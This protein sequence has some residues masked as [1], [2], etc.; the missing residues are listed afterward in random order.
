MITLAV[1]VVS[2]ESST[3]I[4]ARTEATD[5]ATAAFDPEFKLRMQQCGF[6][7]TCCHRACDAAKIA[8]SQTT[9]PFGFSCDY[10]ANTCKAQCGRKVRGNLTPGT[11][12]WVCAAKH[13][14]RDT[15]TTSTVTP[16]TCKSDGGRAATVLEIVRP[17]A[18]ELFDRST[19]HKIEYEDTQE[20]E[21]L[22]FGFKYDL[23][24]A[25]RE[26]EKVK[27]GRLWFCRGE[28]SPSVSRN[29]DINGASF[30]STSGSVGGNSNSGS[31]SSSNSDSAFV[32]TNLRNLRGS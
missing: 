13:A 16:S 18:W 7:G 19:R 4:C 14:I 11:K 9:G 28:T 29:N 17:P 21:T 10:L 24:R 6:L 31:G 26:G 12:I 22:K 5:Q 15:D 30:G 1:V 25:S 27:D 3:N 23:I 32:W 20:R 2:A 8:C